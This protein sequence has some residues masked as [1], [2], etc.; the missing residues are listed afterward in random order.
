MLV[1]VFGKKT[2]DLERE[3]GLQSF[4]SKRSRQDVATGRDLGEFF[5]CDPRKKSTCV[6]A[7]GWKRKWGREKRGPSE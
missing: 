3:M 1:T 5:C 6:Y 4:L 2:P 7:R